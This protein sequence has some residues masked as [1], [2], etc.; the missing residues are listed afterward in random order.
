[1]K[2]QTNSK[3]FYLDGDNGLIIRDHIGNV[4]ADAVDKAGADL[5]LKALNNREPLIKAVNEGMA[6]A[7]ELGTYGKELRARWSKVIKAAQ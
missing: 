3:A 7:D 2:N 5:I 1:M 6:A 4:V